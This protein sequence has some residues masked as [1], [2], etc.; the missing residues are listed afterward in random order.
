M[1]P[2]TKRFIACLSLLLLAS[3]VLLAQRGFVHTKGS[4]L[5]D[6]K[7]QPLILRGTNLGNW[8]E[9]EG[10]MFHFEDNPQS[11]S[12]I[13]AQNSRRPSTELECNSGQNN[14]NNPA[15]PSASP[16]FPRHEMR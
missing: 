11:T 8:L 16:A 1:N 2:T 14:T 6:A 5:V 7:G 9:P 10:Y 15:I 3:P 4:D 12:E 13:E